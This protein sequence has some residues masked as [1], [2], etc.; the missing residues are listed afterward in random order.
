MEKDKLDRGQTMLSKDTRTISHVILPAG[1]IYSV[2]GKAGI[3]DIIAYDENG[4]L[5]PVPWI[6]VYK[7]DFL[8]ARM[9]ARQVLEIG[10][11]ST[12]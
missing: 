11:V 10:Y 4:E 6:A 3:T 8:F 7:G 2:G 12:P 1:D 9:P 5:A